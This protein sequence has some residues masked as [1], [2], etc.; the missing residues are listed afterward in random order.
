M[1][2]LTLK[3]VNAALAARGIKERLVQGYGYLYFIEGEASS[4]YSSSVPVCRLNHLPRIEQ[5]LEAHRALAT[6]RQNWNG[7]TE[8]EYD[9]KYRQPNPMQHIP[10]T[11]GWDR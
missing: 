9:A 6:D 10:D 1:K 11:E 8:A 2:R 7:L 3:A 5:W 4:W